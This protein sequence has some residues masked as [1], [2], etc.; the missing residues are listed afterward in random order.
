MNSQSESIHS[1]IFIF[2]QFSS[3]WH[4]RKLTHQ[5]QFHVFYLIYFPNRQICV[6]QWYSKIQSSQNRVHIFSSLHQDNNILYHL[7]S[8]WPHCK[9]HKKKRFYVFRNIHLIFRFMN[10]CL[11]NFFLTQYQSKIFILFGFQKMKII[12][13]ITYIVPIT[14]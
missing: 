10:G 14:E 4:F 3:K 8:S 12:Y 13:T 5:Y 11:L 2:T 7:K 1:N 6:H 9:K